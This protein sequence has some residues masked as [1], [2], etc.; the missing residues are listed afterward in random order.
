[1]H[2]F[3]PKKIL[4]SSKNINK[5][6]IWIYSAGINIDKNSTNFSRVD[7]EIIDLKKLMDKQCRV[8]L[9]T[10]QGDFQ[11]KTSK[12]LSY[13][14][15][16]LKKKLNV[17]IFYY[18]GKINKNNLLSLKK[19]IKAKSIIILGNTRLLAGEQKNSKNL[20]KLYSVLGN[21]IV[22]GGFSKAH[23]KNASNNAILNYTKGFLSNGIFNE[24]KKLKKWEKFSKRKYLIFL[25]G[26]KKEKAEIGLANLGKHFKY[27][28]PSGLVLN[29]ILKQLGYSIG[30][31]K[32]FK[33]KTLFIVRKFLK[34]HQSK[35]ILP[36]KIITINI[37]TQKRKI[38]P[39]KNIV[40]NDIICGFVISNKLK[41]LILKSKYNDKILLSGTP[42]LIEK[43]VYEPT[44]T[45][46]KYFKLMNKKLLILGGDSANDLK[47]KKN[48]NISSGG[49]ASLSYLA[50]NKLAVTTKLSRRTN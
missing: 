8:F 11:K 24:L 18:A 16:I 36:H 27:V 6:E 46:S 30:S 48:S 35:L 29:T 33:D 45:L 39:L 20:A 49:G 2:I 43:K 7:E 4:L 32:Y 25:G 12:H 14:V 5:K 37:S 13:L 21:K 23:R 19:K 28:V 17:K 47:I 1:M 26:V 9:L 38:C 22:I 42:S 41:K 3:N 50:F 31:S 34:T 15:K 44:F 10:H 40:K